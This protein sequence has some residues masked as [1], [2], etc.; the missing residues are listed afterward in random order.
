M[1]EPRVTYRF[2]IQPQPRLGDEFSDETM[3]AA[4]RSGFVPADP[5]LGHPG[6]TVPTNEPGGGHWS[7]MVVST[8]V[9]RCAITGLWLWVVVAMRTPGK[10]NR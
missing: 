5:P 3:I 6:D 8:D 7:A 10:V 1:S 4:W 9:E 2:P